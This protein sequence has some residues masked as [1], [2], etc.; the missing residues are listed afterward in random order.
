MDFERVPAG[1]IT[2]FAVAGPL[3]AGHLDRLRHE[4]R[5][6][7]TSAAP[8][9]LFDLSQVEFVDSSGIGLLIELFKH[10]K[11]EGGELIVAGLTRYPSELFRILRLDQYIRSYPGRDEAL[12]ALRGAAPT[13]VS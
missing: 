10:A 11:L 12:T 6:A 4:A 13:A 8:H 7:V 3:E 5:E 2:V 1:P 9:L